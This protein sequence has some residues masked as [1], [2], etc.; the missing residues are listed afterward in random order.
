MLIKVMKMLESILTSFHTSHYEMKTLGSFL[1]CFLNKRK[2]LEGI[3]T[4]F[5]PNKASQTNLTKKMM[6]RAQASIKS[7]G[8]ESNC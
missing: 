5:H 3:S 4:S 1:M 8:L 6:D 7:A 2:T